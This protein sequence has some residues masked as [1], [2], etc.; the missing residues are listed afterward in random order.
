VA[1][2]LADDFAIENDESFVVVV[3][4]VLASSQTCSLSWVRWDTPQL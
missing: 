1:T 2:Y 4:V 3:V